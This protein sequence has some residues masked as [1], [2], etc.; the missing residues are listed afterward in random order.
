VH[1]H[2]TESSSFE[3]H[4]GV[5]A[6]GKKR[7]VVAGADVRIGVAQLRGDL[8][9]HGLGLGDLLRV[10]PGSFQHVLEIYVAADVQLVSPF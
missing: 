9:G 2:V 7:N 8:G 4:S 5:P 1:R 10:Q 6:V 3:L